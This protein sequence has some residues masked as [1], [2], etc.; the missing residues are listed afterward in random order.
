MVAKMRRYLIAIAICLAL[1]PLVPAG[2]GL[3]GVGLGGVG[4][5][6]V[7]W[8][9]EAEP[10]RE[11]RIKAAFIYNFAKFTHWPVGSFSDDAA[12]LDFCIYGEDPFGGALDAV[13]GTTIRGRRVAVR[14]VAAIEASAGCHL[15]F[16]SD[17]EAGRV[18]GILAAVG[19]RPVLTVADMPDFA[20]AG[21]IINL[22]T[23]ADDKLRFEINTGTARRAGL[24]FSSK[25]LSLA[26]ITTD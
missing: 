16:I 7:A 19:D 17:S 13:A 10:S 23:T 12:P 2:A 5:G 20:R 9:A 21:G 11:Y 6:G 15:L 18:T 26:E 1:S 22:K 8:A 3:G 24:R 14:R 4:L 25:L